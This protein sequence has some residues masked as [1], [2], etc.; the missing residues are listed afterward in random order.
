MTSI[1]CP[2]VTYG[3]DRVL[4][5]HGEGLRLTRQLIRDVIQPKLDSPALRTLADA[6][7]VPGTDVVITTDAFVVKPLFFPGGDIGRLAV[8]GT[9]NDLT[10]VGATPLAMAIAVM[11][12]E[13]LAMDILAKVLASLGESARTVGLD[14]ITGDT[15]VLP[16]GAI[17]GLFLTA[18]GIGRSRPGVQLG[19][20]RILPGDRI[21]VS[22]TVGD[23]GIAVLAAREELGFSPMPLSDSAP[24][25]ELLR[26]V[27]DAGHDVH[28]LR[29]PTRGGV[30]AVLH[31]IVESTGYSCVVDEASV[32]VAAPIQ[33]ACDL[34]GLDPLY[35][36]NEGKMVLIV[37]EAIAADVLETLRQHPLGK[38]AAIIGEITRSQDAE[39]LVR[40]RVGGLRL[41]DDPAGA[42]LPRI[43]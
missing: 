35:V 24:L 23:H 1:T 34:L 27:W 31:E 22:G 13:G 25:H 32:P 43:C 29:D 33:A 12:E 28:F 8:H 10:A 3:S 18:T 15:K 21:L 26:L 36:A 11:I 41:L 37:R 9:V 20:N 2:A 14:V 38:H 6:A 17:D 16:R 5:A 42:P 40:T 19:M 30:S 7:L 39:V 4:L